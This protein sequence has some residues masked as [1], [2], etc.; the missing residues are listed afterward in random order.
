MYLTVSKR[1]EISLSHRMYHPDFSDDEN[2]AHYGDESKGMHGHGH[3]IVVTF[4]FHGPV[5]E[6]DGMMLNV[7]II[8][9]KVLGERDHD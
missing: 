5:S 4:M 2:F 9:E 6:N 1:F 8:K 7:T 3:N